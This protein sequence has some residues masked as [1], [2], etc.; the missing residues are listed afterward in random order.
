[1]ATVV[2]KVK[3]PDGVVRRVKIDDAWTEQEVRDKLAPYWEKIRLQQDLPLEENF[4]AEAE[5]AEQR[6]AGQDDISIWDKAVGVVDALQSGARSAARGA[7]AYPIQS[8]QA[9]VNNL[10]DASAAKAEFDQRMQNT[11]NAGISTMPQTELG[12]EYLTNATDAFA[13]TGLEGLPPVIAPLAGTV[14]RNATQSVA[15]VRNAVTG[16]LGAAYNASNL[17][18]AVNPTI[19]GA[20]AVGRKVAG[21]NPN[22]AGSASAAKTLQ[23]EMEMAA[24]LERMGTLREVGIEGDVGPTVGQLTR[25]PEAQSQEAALRTMGG[26]ADLQRRFDAQNEALTGELD[27]N[28]Y[29][30]GK[31]EDGDYLPSSDLETGNAVKETLKQAEADSR[32]RYKEAYKSADNS[33]EANI[34]VNTNPLTVLF[35][36]DYMKRF[37][38]NKETK[39]NL[40]ALI[41]S[42]TDPDVGIATKSKDGVVT[43]NDGV[44]IKQLEDFRSDINSFFDSTNPQQKRLAAKLIESIDEQLDKVPGGDLYRNAR[45][46][47][48]RHAEEY[49]EHDFVARAT[50]TKGRT[51]AEAIPPEQITIKVRGLPTQELARFRAQIINNGGEAAWRRV[52]SGVLEQIKRDAV[53]NNS[54][55][56]DDTGSISTARLAKSIEDL[57]NA[58][59]LEIMFGPEVAEQLRTVVKAA[60][61]LTQ[62]VKG[63]QN[64]SGTANAQQAAKSVLMRFMDMKVPG[65]STAVRFVEKSQAEKAARAMLDGE[66]MLSDAL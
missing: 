21:D 12:A 42:M 10:G 39:G 53:N 62:P 38:I 59:K 63:T 30:V 54:R 44:T 40:S 52:S 34:A 11:M 28:I 18:L 37:K 14:A 15:P 58:G 56:I 4:A 17:S 26:G 9:I 19:A 31:A 22:M 66:G 61:I 33:E 29:N 55:G 43:F 7:V 51:S 8:A 20:R 16:A 13:A 24:A 32:S 5:I 6:K 36:S 45:A 60:R 47:R 27:R 2:K 65:A 1:M 46:E 57:D 49:E 3:F 50:G 41:K 35:N 25:N 48:R 23:D 64:P